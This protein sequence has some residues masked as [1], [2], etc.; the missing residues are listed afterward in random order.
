MN[1]PKD[2]KVIA[3]LRQDPHNANLGTERGLNILDGSLT[4]Y[5]AGRSILVDRAGMAIAGNKTLQVATD[6]AFP[7]R[8]VR[9]N[10]T[11]LVVVQRTDLDLSSAGEEQRRARRLA[12]LDN[13]SS[14]LGLEWDAEQILALVEAD[15]GLLD[16]LFDDT[17]LTEL[18][19]GLAEEPPAALEPEMQLSRANVPDALWPSD[20]EWGV[21]LLDSAM[22]AQAVDLPVALWGAMGR[23]KRMRGTWVFYCDDYRFEALWHDPSGV[24]NTQCASA[25][26]PNFTVG[27]QTPRAVALWQIYRK[28]YLAR[29][30]QSCGVRVLVDVNMDTTT[31]GDIML[32]GV[33]EGGRAY[34]T[35]GY[36]DRLE[37]TVAEYEM[38]R[39]RAGTEDILF[40][41]YGGGK[42]CK[43]LALEQGWIYV[44]EHMDMKRGGMVGG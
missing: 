39:E 1:D 18:L 38:A 6:K 9:T 23:K 33:P 4:E 2:L 22:Q 37:F 5:G 36:T 40:L 7:I 10:G 43:A 13:R 31:F 42:A 12:I 41:L 34:A 21:P 15:D 14:E 20:N 16:G 27:P 35:R 19:A 11:E 28:R 44:S 29:W 17:E 25:V 8:V 3:D 26:E 30:W 24:V 32:L